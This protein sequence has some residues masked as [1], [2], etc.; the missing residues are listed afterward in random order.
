MSE[1]ITPPVFGRI[2]SV[3]LK[4]IV[5]SPFDCNDN[6]SVNWGSVVFLFLQSDNSRVFCC[7]GKIWAVDLPCNSLLLFRALC[8]QSKILSILTLLSP[9]SGQEQKW[10]LVLKYSW[11][12]NTRKMKGPGRVVETHHPTWARRLTGCG[13]RERDLFSF[14]QPDAVKRVSYLSHPLDRG[15]HERWT[16]PTEYRAEP[17]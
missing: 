16:L 3:H 11:G 8:Q 12:R 9:L 2:L 13:C 1:E 4:T 10:K 17:W 14:L 5:S 15:G 6:P 7:L